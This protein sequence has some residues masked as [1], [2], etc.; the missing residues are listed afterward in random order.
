MGGYDP[1]FWAVT[2][3]SIPPDVTGEPC[4]GKCLGDFVCHDGECTPTCDASKPCGPDLVCDEAVG[5]C[6]P[7]PP[8]L[9]EEC[10]GPCRQDYQCYSDTGEPPGTCVPRCP[11]DGACPEGYECAA[12]IDLCV[13]SSGAPAENG[14]ADGSCSC[15]S[16]G[17]TDPRGVGLLLALAAIAR[18]RRLSCAD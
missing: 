2:G 16:P 18:R 10:A 17:A 11:T 9:G 4:D 5:G 1:P 13:P 6:V 14:G 15:R 12:D 7:E 3:E 8:P